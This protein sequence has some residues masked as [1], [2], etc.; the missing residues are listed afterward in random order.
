MMFYVDVD[1]D[2]DVNVNVNVD[3]DVDVDVDHN[4]FCDT[5]RHYEFCC[6]ASF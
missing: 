1:V 6:K 3:V 2:V 4:Q 5:R